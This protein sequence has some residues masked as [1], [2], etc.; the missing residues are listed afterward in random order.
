[1]KSA[2]K[3]LL[4]GKVSLAPA[5]AIFL[6]GFCVRLA[7]LHFKGAVGGYDTLDYLKLADN[8]YN[9]GAYSLSD[10]PNLVPSIRRAPVYPYFLA[11]MQW[12]GGGTVSQWSVGFI[13]CVL[14]SFTA[15][16]IFLLA[17]KVVSK[18][19]AVAAAVFYIVHPGVLARSR[20]LL[21]ETLFA[22]FLVVGVLVL[23]DAFE[24]ETIGRLF[25]AGFLLGLAVLTRPIAVVFPVLFF[26][27]VG[28]K[29]NSKKYYRLTAIAG[30]VFLLTLAPWLIRCYRVSG[31]F[32]FVQ[33]VTA[34]QF[35]APT[36]V[37]LAQWD[38][39]K[40]WTEFF[41]PNT[42]DEYF[43]MLARA[44]SPADFIAAEKTGRQRAVEN[45]S[46]HPREYL[47]SRA[48]TYPYFFISSF[49]NF[50]GINKSF[51]RLLAEGYYFSLTFKILL[52]LI[53]SLLPFGLSVIGLRRISQNSTTAFCALIWISV[54]LIHL[55]MWIEYRF[56]IP[57]VP[58]Q[59]VSAAAGLAVLRDRFW[60]A[61]SVKT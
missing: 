7:Y 58:F 33:G 14:D 22:F 35:Y 4:P 36:R 57:F 10:A 27:A 30:T 41:D 3:N 38:E 39:N 56:W 34:F 8:L 60:A 23:I 11:F 61:K 29:S 18:P 21:T 55:P 53:F 2:L 32:V 44:E 40:L 26:A 37:D 17:R 59:I 43:R 31:Q 49:D 25:W 47:I 20:L 5:G 54:L 24:K 1:V 42:D 45:I 12:L 46:A 19:L 15:A 48:K 50:T 28:F 52:L 51:G 6:I 13:Q 16:A 9:Y